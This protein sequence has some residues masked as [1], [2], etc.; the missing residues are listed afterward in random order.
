M[1]ALRVRSY[2]RDGEYAAVPDRA[3]L[4]RGVVAPGGML[5]ISSSPP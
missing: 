3:A 4:H 5:P 2:E 1:E